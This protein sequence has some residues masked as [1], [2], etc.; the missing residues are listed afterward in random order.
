MRLDCGTGVLNSLLEGGFDCGGITTIYGPAATGK[1][2]CCLLAAIAIAKSKGKTIFVD[3]ENGFSVE[4]MKQ[5]TKEY[6]V[7]L[8]S[9]FLIKID[10][11]K[12]QIEK[13]K[14]VYDLIKKVD[15]DLLVIDT[16]GSHYRTVLKE[17]VYEVNRAMSSQLQILNDIAKNHKT[18]VLITNQV[19][20]NIQNQKTTIV[21]GDMLRNWSKCLVELKK[22]EGN[23]RV[24]LLKKHREIKEKEILFE[25][26][27][28]G[29][30][31]VT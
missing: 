7:V 19:Y 26:V 18:T 5:L 21:G 2:T 29:F 15:I 28:K 14:W 24:A 23:R 9:I 3:S 17:D 30:K 10:S 16:I 25:I 20:T 8:D 11:F 13:I 22:L 27:E 6:K 1:T 4:R 31:A 12:N